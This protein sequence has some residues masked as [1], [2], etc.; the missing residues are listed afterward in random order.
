MTLLQ[1]PPNTLNELFKGVYTEPDISAAAS[2]KFIFFA[3]LLLIVF[4]I[5]KFFLPVIFRNINKK[6]V[7]KR[8]LPLFELVSWCIYFV[9]S[10]HLFSLNNSTM[11]FLPITLLSIIL[12]IIGWYAFRDILAGIVM[13]TDRSCKINEVVRIDNTTAKI[14][15]FRYRNLQLETLS[16][17]TI[18]IPYTKVYNNI[19]VKE[20][21]AEL[22]VSHSFQMNIPSEKFNANTLEEVKQYILSMPWASINKLPQINILEEKENFVNIKATIFALEK[23]FLFHIEQRVRKQYSL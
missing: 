2:F 14:I 16:G 20:H 18:F 9:W 22:I 21:P 3:I 19:M 5:F 23:D 11:L 15:S 17:E 7:I 12:V 1:T 8:Y 6:R 10:I 13:K 4:R